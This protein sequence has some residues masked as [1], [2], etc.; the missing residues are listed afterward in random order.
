MY[1]SAPMFSGR[2]CSEGVRQRVFCLQRTGSGHERLN[3]I[4]GAH[5]APPA[6]GVRDPDSN[7]IIGE[8]GVRPGVERTGADAAGFS[9]R[10]ARLHVRRRCSTCPAATS[11][12]RPW[13]AFAYAAIMPSV[14][15]ADLA[16]SSGN[17]ARN[18]PTQH[19]RTL[20]IGAGKSSL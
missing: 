5:A 1:I 8:V 11:A 17:A 19:N 13:E 10:G 9:R 18:R 20:N 14:H 15:W 6:V 7:S 12:P 3:I 16:L 4:S 2:L